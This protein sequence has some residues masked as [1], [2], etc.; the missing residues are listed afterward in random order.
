[1]IYGLAADREISFLGSAQQQ[2][3]G[4]FRFMALPTTQNPFV[5]ASSEAD[6]RAQFIRTVYTHVAGAWLVFFL[7]ECVLLALPITHTFSDLVLTF[8]GGWLAVLGLFMG[9]SWLARVLVNGGLSIRAQ[10]AGL[11]I[12]VVA[13]AI[14]FAPLIIVTL[15]LAG[16]NLLINAVLLSGA[17]FLGLTAIVFTT[18]KDFSFLRSILAVAGFVS[19]GLIVAS[20]V[21]GFNLGLA[22]SAGMIAVAGGAILY[23]TSRIVRECRPDEYVSA[24]LELFASMALLLWYVLRMLLAFGRKD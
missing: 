14:V 18:K 24:A 16:P 2:P 22:F 17:L 9:V 19:L 23:D 7:L 5:V 8:P 20:I 4:W 1:V 11:A 13:E 15:R 12:Y 3:R 10:Y 21:F 6:E